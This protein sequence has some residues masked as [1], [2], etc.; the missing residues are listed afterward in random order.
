[1][2]DYLTRVLYHRV[3]TYD[4]SQIDEHGTTLKKRYPSKMLQF[5]NVTLQKRYPSRK[6]PFNICTYKIHNLAKILITY[7]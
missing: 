1:M 7:N 3:M 4:I 2:K 5:Q 6:L